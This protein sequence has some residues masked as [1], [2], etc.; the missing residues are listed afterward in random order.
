MPCFGC[1]IL[2]VTSGVFFLAL[3]YR[4]RIKCQTSIMTIKPKGSNNEIIY[5]KSKMSQSMIQCN[6]NVLTNKPLIC[7]WKVH[8]NSCVAS[9]KCLIHVLSES[10]RS[11]IT[12]GPISS[13]YR[14]G[15]R[16]PQSL[17]ACGKT[18]LLNTSTMY[19]LSKELMLTTLTPAIIWQR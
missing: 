6:S 5:L 1:W 19:F 12:L 13:F 7:L 17:A 9:I 16:D 8:F 15:S 10:W 3:A 11:E 14:W 2:Q 4:L 18:S